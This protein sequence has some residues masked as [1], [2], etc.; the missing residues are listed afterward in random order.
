M[1]HFILLCTAFFSFLTYS[2]NSTP[3]NELAKTGSVTGIVIDQS[4]QQPIPYATVVLKQNGENIVGGIT[5]DNGSFELTKIEEGTYTFEI[6]FIGYQTYSKEISV[7][8]NK[9]NL[10]TITL[11]EN[12]T[13]LEGVD[14]VAERSTIEQKIDRK[15][16]NVGKDLTTQG[17]TASDIMNNIPSVNVDQQTG[18]LSMRGNSNVRVMVDGKLSNVPVAQL[19]KQIPSTSI[20]KIELITNPSAKYNPEGMSGIINIVLYKDANIG[21]NGNINLGLAYQDEAKF[22][23]SGDLNY[24]NGKFNVYGSYG[25][26]IGKYVNDG[27]V[28][29]MDDENTTDF[30]ENQFQYFSFLNNN[31]SHL[32]KA[33]I[34]FYLN[35]KNTISVFTNQNIFDGKGRGDTQIVNMDPS[36]DNSRQVFTNENSNHNEQYNFDYKRDFEKEGH[37]IEF[38]IDYNN[39]K[40]EEDADFNYIGASTQPDYQDFVDTRR[41]QTIANLDYVNPLSEKSKLEL[42]LEYRT[43]ETDVDYSSTGFTFNSGG[44][45]IPTPDTDFIYGMDIYSAYTT[46]GQNFEKWSYQVGARFEDVS[47]KADTNSVRSFTDDYKQIYPSAFVTYNPSEKNQFQVSFSRRVDRPGLGQ[48]N[49]IREWS[50]PQISSYGNDELLPQFTNSYETNYTR[51]L[52]HGSITFGVYYRSIED[53]INQVLYVDRLDLTKQI[54]TYDNFDNT[55][56]YGFEI[57]TNYK[58]LDWWSINGSIDMY[59]QKQRGLTEQLIPD[60]NDVTVDDIITEE[61]E[62]NNVAFNAR[63]NNNFTVTKNLTLSLFGYYRGKNKG[64]QMDAKPM[65][66]VNTGARYS[67]AG[68]KGTFSLNFNDIFNTMQFSF[69]G[70]RPYEQNGT[71]NWESRTIF[72]GLSYRF[73]SGKNR[74]VQR[75]QRDSNTK[76]GGGIM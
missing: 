60:D 52:E 5:A 11:V 17:A 10:G 25:N 34:D 36:V 27:V 50:T 19:L 46:F 55:N 66:F 67:F 33:G 30:N 48:V 64:L 57:S 75:K 72:A 18:Q 12:V 68:G 56:A 43:F 4:L 23:S 62:V 2:Q 22:N 28:E 14:V 37:N 26:N 61:V 1:K 39:F 51:R 71:F 69:E 59:A 44:V 73:G 74:K 16:I 29:R 54:L 15:V 41:Q 53:E 13:E 6:Q 76:E 70:Q 47:V 49:P 24:R 38:E 7:T 8:G 9:T 65:Y 42:G 35:E 58:P 31:K 40:D 20:K 63:L 32:Y 45:L 21:F 3:N